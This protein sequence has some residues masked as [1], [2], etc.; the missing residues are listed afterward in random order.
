MHPLQAAARRPVDLMLPGAG[1]GAGS[2]P[3]EVAGIPVAVKAG[4]AGRVVFL[5]ALLAGF[6][7]GC[8]SSPHPGSSAPTTPPA[9]SSAVPAATTAPAPAASGTG[10]T[11]QPQASGSVTA[12]PGATAQESADLAQAQQDI[13]QLEQEL[14]QVDAGLSKDPN[15]EGDVN[16]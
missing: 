7:A 13:D 6:A 10:A 16:P 8:R 12:I 4:A 14:S 11:A 3:E 9:A 15:T 5:A 2:G 1:V